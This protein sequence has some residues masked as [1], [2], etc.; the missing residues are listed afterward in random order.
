[1]Q[2]LR[3]VAAMVTALT[4]F[5]IVGCGERTVQ[6][7]STPYGT[8]APQERQ[9]MSTR[10]KVL[11]LA[12]A[13]A[14]Y[15]LWQK[16]KDKPETATGAEGRYYRSRN[17]RIYFRDAKGQAHWVTPPQQPIQVPADEY[18]RYFRRDAD[19]DGGDVIRESPV[20]VGY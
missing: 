12:G 4:M 19:R 6:G 14:V 7:Q 18:E 15:Y 13:A 10:N 2:R 17:G 20:P 9:G 3:A 8:P 1:M 11:L 16:N 5:G